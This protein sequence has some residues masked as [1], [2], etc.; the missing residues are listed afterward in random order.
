M[1]VR[2]FDPYEFEKH[3]PRE[4]RFK[5]VLFPRDDEIFWV[6]RGLFD[7]EGLEIF[8]DTLK[9]YGGNIKKVYLTTFR[10]EERPNLHK[11]MSKGRIAIVT[12]GEII[13]DDYMRI[14]N[15]KGNETPKRER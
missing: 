14:M 4:M 15:P 10:K 5:E 8:Q 2:K 7:R 9:E 1:Q 3:I 6:T 13:A 12:K 11:D